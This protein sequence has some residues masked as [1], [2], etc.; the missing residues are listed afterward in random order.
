MAATRTAIGE[1]K[2]TYMEA[3]LANVWSTP[4]LTQD[5]SAI[6]LTQGA[7]ATTVKL[8]RHPVVDNTGRVA[9]DVASPDWVDAQADVVV[10]AAAGALIEFTEPV[11]AWYRFRP[12]LAATTYFS[13]DE[14]E[15]I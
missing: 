1:T 5:A 13:T 11:V 3:L 10:D 6:Q 12:S 2:A 8:Q 14:P 7:A 4:H 15:A 9:P